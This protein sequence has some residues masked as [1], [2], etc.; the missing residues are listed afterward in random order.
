MFSIWTSVGW[1]LMYGNSTKE[2]QSGKSSHRNIN[3]GFT[4]IVFRIELAPPEVVKAYKL[5]P[6]EAVIYSV[7]AGCGN[8]NKQ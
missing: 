4:F 5:N 7:V 6:S 8:S 3:V 2:D 1:Y